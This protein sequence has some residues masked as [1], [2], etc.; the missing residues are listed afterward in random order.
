MDVD[1]AHHGAAEAPCLP[2][3]AL[4]SPQHSIV[5]RTFPKG[6]PDG[7]AERL[8]ELKHLTTT[9]AELLARTSPASQLALAAELARLTAE[10]HQL[11]NPQRHSIQ[12]EHH[13]QQP[14]PT[15]KGKAATCAKHMK[16][17]HSGRSHSGGT[18]R[19]RI[20]SKPRLSGT[21][22]SDSEWGTDDETAQPSRISH[23]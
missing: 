7:T 12:L 10:S 21:H 20:M 16:K 19:N 4:D 15:G 8:V 1:T 13:P 11:R 5:Q 6:T 17:Q 3:I 2:D 23:Q 14:L 22:A 18:T 9:T